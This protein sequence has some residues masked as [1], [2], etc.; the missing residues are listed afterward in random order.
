MST[1]SSQ[2][3]APTAPAARNAVIACAAAATVVAAT[4]VIDLALRPMST[5]HLHTTGD[6]LFTAIGIPFVLLT[7][8]AVASLHQAQ[9]GRDGRLGRIGFLVVAVCNLALLPA[10]VGSLVTA[11]ENI[12][13]PLY[14]VATL[15]S[16]AGMVLFAVGTFRGHVL[17]RF[18]GP[19]LAVA[20]VVGGLLAVAPGFELIPAAV[21]ALT[22]T[23]L[24]RRRVVAPRPVTQSAWS[25]AATR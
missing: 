12:F 21:L 20:W 7:A 1:P 6:Y 16:F 3:P 18:I 10:F 8:A 9:A 24:R 23:T 25:Q 5:D 15:G 2:A 14:P 19:A 4:G 11:N 13:S 17:P 22:A